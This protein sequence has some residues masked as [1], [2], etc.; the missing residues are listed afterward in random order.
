VSVS[1]LDTATRHQFN[2]PNTVRGA[3]VVS[4]NED[5]PAFQAGLREGDV[6]QE[7]NRHPAQS[8]DEAITLSEKAK[9]KSVLLRVWSRGG[10][11]FVVV[12]KDQVG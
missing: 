1:D 3:L 12:A 10:S 9:G 2:I 6:I 5:A 4:V 8:A 7:I 11:R